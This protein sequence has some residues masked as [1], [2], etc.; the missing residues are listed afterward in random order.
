MTPATGTYQSKLQILFYFNLFLEFNKC[1]AFEY[2]I[3]IRR[4]AA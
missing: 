1:S 4:I 2:G 3:Q